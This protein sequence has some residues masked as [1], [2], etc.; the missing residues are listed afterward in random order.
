MPLPQAEKVGH[1]FPPQPLLLLRSPLPP[2]Q[3][4][5]SIG[6]QTEKP[7]KK[8]PGLTFH[9]LHA[10][11][12]PHLPCED[13]HLSLFTLLAQ[14]LSPLQQLLVPCPRGGKVVDQEVDI[15]RYLSPCSKN[16]PEKECSWAWTGPTTPSGTP[17]QRVSMV[18]AFS[19][20]SLSREEARLSTSLVVAR[21]YF[22]VFVGTCLYFLVILVFLGSFWFFLVLFCTVWFI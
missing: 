7:V 22:L 19:V 21:G 5:G 6:P 9:P 12:P 18:L 2:S 3:G 17:P 16:P 15:F 20:Y 11:H 14:H 13:G 8:A 10:E 1:S 4:I